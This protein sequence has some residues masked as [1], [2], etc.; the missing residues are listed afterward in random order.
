MNSETFRRASDLFDSVCDLPV[1]ERSARLSESC[2]DDTELFALVEELLENDADS[3]D[4]DEPPRPISEVAAPFPDVPGFRITGRLGE[5]GM[6]I[7]FRAVQETTRREVALKFFGKNLVGTERSLARFE[8]EIEVAARIEHPGIARVYESGTAGGV[9]YYA[10]ELIEGSRLDVYVAMNELDTQAVVELFAALCNAVQQAH[11]AG[12]IHRDLKPSNVLVRHSGQPVVVDF[13][14]AKSFDGDD[15][16]GQ[17]VSSEGQIVG[18]PS[19]M[20]PEQASGSDTAEDTRSDV[21][22]LGV[23]LF[24][25]LTGKYPHDASGSTLDVLRRIS[26]TDALQ[27]RKA[28]PKAD[29]ELSLILAK[30]LARER[31]ERYSTAGE[32][33]DELE[34]WLT[35]SPLQVQ[36]PSTLFVLRRG[37]RRHRVPLTVAS[38]VLTAA[39]VGIVGWIISLRASREETEQFAYGYRMQLADRTLREGQ[40]ARA[41]SYLDRCPPARRDWEWEYLDRQVDSTK[42]FPHAGF[43][44]LALGHEDHSLRAVGTGSISGNVDDARLIIDRVDGEILHE[45]PYENSVTA[46]EFSSDDREVWVGARSVPF[47]RYDVETGEKLAEEPALGFVQRLE[48]SPDR[49]TLAIADFKKG[50]VLRNLE[51][52]RGRRFPFHQT[53]KQYFTFTPDSKRVFISF[54]Q[55]VSET[56]TALY[57]DVESGEVLHSWRHTRFW[58][59]SLH[60]SGNVAVIGNERGFWIW[61]LESN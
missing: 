21:F 59:S 10:M 50:V 36:P 20:S 35:G 31:T 14:L 33:G 26:E 43:I 11:L 18:T 54:D 49:K 19:Y 58:A 29:P 24:R 4:F 46:V 3:V 42:P 22:S 32:L 57:V 5:G 12:V 17:T 9:P 37:V 40:H 27:L 1:A 23:L 45:I 15:L 2:G 52:R 41:K 44:S 28:D 55:W 60:P 48:L 51:L 13:G 38:I 39:L 16:D 53:G 25:S 6:G 56:G 7:V 47:R 30:A 8:R 61:N 34:R